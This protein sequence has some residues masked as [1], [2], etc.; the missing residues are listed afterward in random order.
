ML[1]DGCPENPALK[2]HNNDIEMEENQETANWIPFEQEETEEDDE[3]DR[4][5]EV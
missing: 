2:R 3:D 5:H 1:K 4:E